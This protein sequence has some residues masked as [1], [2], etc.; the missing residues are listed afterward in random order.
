MEQVTGQQAK[1]QQS[2]TIPKV[3][4]GV[5]DQVLRYVRRHYM[6]DAEILRRCP[7]SVA[8]AFLQDWMAA[9][10]AGVTFVEDEAEVEDESEC[11]CDVCVIRRREEAL[12]SE[13]EAKDK[14][15]GEVEGEVEVEVK[16]EVLRDTYRGIVRNGYT[17]QSAL[18]YVAAV[19]DMDTHEVADL[20]HIAGRCY[21][22]ECR[23]QRIKRISQADVEEV[24]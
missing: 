17:F 3:P 7:Q 9:E 8:A 11:G 15:Q 21:C 24:V 16:V 5:V 19:Y 23:M 6:V 18:E 4:T 20:L 14:V 1:H 10:G 22:P 13:G 2:I 12:T